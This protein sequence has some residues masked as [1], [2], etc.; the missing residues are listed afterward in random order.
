MSVYIFPG[1]RG[2]AAGVQCFR[3]WTLE[4]DKDRD[5][6]RNLSRVLAPED[7][8][9]WTNYFTF[10][11]LDFFICTVEILMDLPQKNVQ[12]IKYELAHWYKGL[13]TVPVALCKY[14]INFGCCWLLL[15]SC[16]LPDEKKLR[17]RKIGNLKY[18]STDRQ[19]DT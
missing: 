16:W 7:L 17:T 11:C 3:A 13:S 9:P 2:E 14:L 6:E 1:N 5:R 15:L 18:Y 12:K 8:W 19:H 10:Q 4:R